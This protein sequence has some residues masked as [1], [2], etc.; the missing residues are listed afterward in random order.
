[1][2]G[3]LRSQAGQQGGMLGIRAESR[4][5]EDSSRDGGQ[6]RHGWPTPPVD[7]E[8]AG[9]RKRTMRHMKQ[10]GESGIL[11]TGQ[12]TLDGRARAGKLTELADVREHRD[13]PTR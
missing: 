1:M 6:A 10:S 5:H 12:R 7:V 9:A 8:P 2:N 4:P 11:E 3:G 13:S